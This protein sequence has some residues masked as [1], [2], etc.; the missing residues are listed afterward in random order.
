MDGWASWTS[1][2]ERVLRFGSRH[3][4][5]GDRSHEAGTLYAKH[6]REVHKSIKGGAS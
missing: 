3:F 2:T 5:T 1:H 6:D 4:R